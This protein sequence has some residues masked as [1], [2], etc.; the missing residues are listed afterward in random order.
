MKAWHLHDLE[1]ADLGRKPTILFLYIFIKL[2]WLL[3]EITVVIVY[4]K[5]P[6]AF[7]CFIGSIIK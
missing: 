2:S 3:I 4:F 6:L 1:R 7:I 5:V